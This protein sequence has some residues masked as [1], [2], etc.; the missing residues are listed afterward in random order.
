MP[1]KRAWQEKAK[2]TKTGKRRSV[3]EDLARLG[4][5]LLS[6]SVEVALTQ[7][8]S[9]PGRRPPFTLERRSLQLGLRSLRFASHKRSSRGGPVDEHPEHPDLPDGLGELVEINRLLYVSVH[10]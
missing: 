6:V 9:A 8:T 5:T 3:Q 1:R 4:R 2:R 7:E 10:S